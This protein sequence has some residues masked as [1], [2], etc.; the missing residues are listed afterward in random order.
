MWPAPPR[1]CCQ[2]VP[3]LPCPR[4][5]HT[6]DVMGIGSDGPAGASADDIKGWSSTQ[7]GGWAGD[8]T[9]LG[10]LLPGGRRR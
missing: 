9:L 3:P 6:S 7:V 1:H 10:G 2:T 4:R 5:W 8:R